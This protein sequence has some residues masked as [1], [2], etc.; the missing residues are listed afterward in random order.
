MTAAFG[1]ALLGALRALLPRACPGCGAQLGAHAGLCPACRATLR[2]QVQA[3]SPLRAHPEPH[4]VTLGPYSGVRRRAVRELKFAQARDLAR[5]LGETLATGVPA[6]W[7]VQAVIP[8]P[9][10]P[11]RQ[12]QRGFNQAELLGRALASALAVPCVPALTRTRATAQ[13]ARRHGTQR[14]DLHGA[15]RAHE[16]F[17]PSGPVLLIDDVL[18][19]GHTAQACQDALKQ[20]GAP[21]VYVAVVAR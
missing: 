9:L 19:T 4:L 13:Q 14:E 15:F 8:V 12:R 17:L 16:G 10:H 11:D 1:T 5:I 6:D 7:N 2:P 21:Q 18:T 20:A 3:H